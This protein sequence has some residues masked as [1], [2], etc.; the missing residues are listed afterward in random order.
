MKFCYEYCRCQSQT[1]I[2]VVSVGNTLY[3]NA[4]LKHK[5]LYHSSSTV[6]GSTSERQDG[7]GTKTCSSELNDLKC[8]YSGKGYD[9]TI[10]LSLTR[11]DDIP[12]KVHW[13]LILVQ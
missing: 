3:F 4:Y 1:V 7:G 5:I 12:A 8:T 10:L 9:L 11:C 2:E 6:H 13:I